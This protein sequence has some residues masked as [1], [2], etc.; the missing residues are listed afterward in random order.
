[1]FE[2]GP[3]SKETS[4]RRLLVGSVEELKWARV[5]C[6]EKIWALLTSVGWLPSKKAGPEVNHA[7]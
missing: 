3:S 7:L 1:M 5:E 2:N 6:D 4:G